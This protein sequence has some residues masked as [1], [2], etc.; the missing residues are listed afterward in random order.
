MLKYCASSNKR[1]VL[2]RVIYILIK[3]KGNFGLYCTCVFEM[4]HLSFYINAQLIY[5]IYLRCIKLYYDL[6]LLLQIRS[7]IPTHVRKCNSQLI[8][9]RFYYHFDFLKPTFYR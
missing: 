4:P 9:N 2:L 5:I 3:K 6:P 1:L 7:K 8:C